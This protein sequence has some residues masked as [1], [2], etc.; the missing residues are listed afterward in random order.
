MALAHFIHI[1]VRHFATVGSLNLF[2]WVSEMHR[3]FSKRII[4]Q[5]QI[6]QLEVVDIFETFL[7]APTSRFPFMMPHDT[8][9]CKRNF[10]LI[11]LIFLIR[12]SRLHWTTPLGYMCIGSLVL[13]LELNACEL[14]V[15]MGEPYVVIMM[16]LIHYLFTLFFCIFFI[17]DYV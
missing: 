10:V 13:P 6:S 5:L 2:Y 9:L 7:Q 12:L 17:H 14:F 15:T 3:I 4:I 1:I 16:C 11:L 8:T